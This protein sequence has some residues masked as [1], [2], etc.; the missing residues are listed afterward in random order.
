[1]AGDHWRIFFAEDR[2]DLVQSLRERC[3]ELD[4]ADALN[5][6][7]WAAVTASPE[8]SRWLSYRGFGLDRQGDEP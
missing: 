7:V 5:D 6:Q 1:V 4:A 2:E 3:E 8:D